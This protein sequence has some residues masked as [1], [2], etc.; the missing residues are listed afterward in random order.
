MQKVI[1]SMIKKTK[2]FILFSIAVAIGSYF[3]GLNANAEPPVVEQPQTNQN[4][5]KEKLEAYIKFTKILN[6]IEHEYVD[7]T[8]TT[9]LVDKALKGLMSNLDAH[10]SYMD[11]KEYKDLNVHT[12]GEFGG[13]GISVGMKDGS[14]TVIAP[15]QDTPAYKAGVKAGD[16]IIKL[17]NKATMGMNIDE[18]VSI[19]RGKPG[20]S[21][22]LT[23]LRK[24]ETKPREIKINR[25]IIKVQS[26]FA[27]I[28]DGDLLYIQVTSFDQN[29]VKEVKKALTKYSKA[30]GIVLDLRSNP[31][32]L[33]DQAV[34]LTDLFVDKGVIVSQKGRSKAENITFSAKADKDDVKTPMVVLVDGGSASAS[35]IVSGALQDL[36]RAV[37][38]GEKTF[39][40]GSVQA[41][42]PL[43]NEEGLRLTVARYYLPS[44]RSIQAKGVDPDVVV[45]LGSI[46]NGTTNNGLIKESELDKHLTVGD[47]NTTTEVMQN[48]LSNKG[49]NIS[50]SEV[51]KDSQ[52]KSA[53]DILKA[54]IITEGRK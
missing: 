21:I 40:K 48:T 9:I 47:A 29:V 20:S 26:V 50:E 28:I 22:T 14:L 16:V 42:I 23:I 54:L 51:N 41:V 31:G 52:L 8:N 53:I 19:M 7:E 36:K 27:K 49:N 15:I 17:D 39:G 1:I 46:T 37:V 35:E 32:G 3:I 38:V 45:H 12:K 13:L 43:G 11:K 25:A 4:I 18:A 10:S 30:K 6:L 2:P 44:G 5:S 24:N 33:L 34:G